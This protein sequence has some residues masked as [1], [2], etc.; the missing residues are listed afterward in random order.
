MNLYDVHPQWG[1]CKAMGVH[2]VHLK[3]ATILITIQYKI[4][5]HWKDFPIM[6]EFNINL[7]NQGNSNTVGSLKMVFI[8]CKITDPEDRIDAFCLYT[9]NPLIPIFNTVVQRR[10]VQ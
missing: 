4:L 8:N 2:S 3:K 10:K 7:V 5:E 1:W 6:V 9:K